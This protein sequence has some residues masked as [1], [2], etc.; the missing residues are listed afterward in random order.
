MKRF[1]GTKL[2][3][4]RPMTR[5]SYMRF[6]LTV[7]RMEEKYPELNVDNE[8]Y[9][10]DLVDDILDKQRGL[11]ERLRLPPSKALAEAVKQIMARRP[12]SAAADGGADKGAPAG[13]AA[14]K[15][16]ERKAAAVAKNLDAAGRQPG[17]LRETGLDADKA[18]Q[19]KPLPSAADMTYEEFNALPEA[20]RAKMRGDFS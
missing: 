14:A 6:D 1:V 15:D 12:A 13:L 3:N 19:T 8:A 4:A 11:I 10:Q 7:E 5:A 2:V 18:G 16:G 9:D 17:S 20:T